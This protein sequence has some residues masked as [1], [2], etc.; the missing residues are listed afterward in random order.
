MVAQDVENV[1]PP[2]LPEWSLVSVIDVSPHE[3]G[4]WYVATTAY[5]LDD[6]R[7]YLYKTN[8]NGET[9]TKITNGIPDGEFT[10]VI[11]EDPNRRGLLYAGTETGIWISF[12]D[13]ENWQRF[14]WEPLASAH[15]TLPV[16][17]IHDLVIKDKDL[18]VATHGRSFW[19]LDDLSPLHQ[20]ADETAAESMK[21]LKPRDTIRFKHYG[22][23]FGMT[24]DI[25]NYK[26]TGPVT[27]AYKPTRNAMDSF[28]EK[29]LDAGENPPQ[30]AI[31]HYWLADEPGEGEE[32]T[33]TIKEASGNVVRTFSS[34]DK[35][36]P[37]APAQAGAN[38]L[39]WDFR[40]D[41]PAQI[42]RDR[43]PEGMEAM[44]EQ[45]FG[46]VIPPVA[47]PGTYSVTLRRG[48]DEQ[49]VEFEILPDPRIPATQEDLVAQFEL[50]LQIRERISEL[51]TAVNRIRRVKK[52]A[53]TWKERDAEQFGDDVATLVEGLESIEDMLVQLDP[54]ALKPGPARLS[55]RFGALAVMVDEADAR[56]TDQDRRGLRQTCQRPPTRTEPARRHAGG[57]RRRIQP[58]RAGIRS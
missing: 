37:K 18:L 55:G 34:S 5:K 8:D 4:T 20:I 38:R 43:E 44:I 3:R 24:P 9:W 2:D 25:V 7:P 45:W 27:V 41:P 47:V 22:R 10:R 30:G 40:Y 14:D 46:R 49:T 42:E 51:N 36:P 32:I 16:T 58:A 26:M 50:K 15:E 1:T 57:R 33:V 48:G 13:G 39:V 31:I 54:E 19:I 21:L 12:D 53:G 6:T 29:F 17:P 23:A 11:R 35:K 52:Q 56:P 28:D